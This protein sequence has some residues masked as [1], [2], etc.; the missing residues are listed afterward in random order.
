MSRISIAILQAENSI[1]VLDFSCLKALRSGDTLVVWKLDRLG[2][3]LKH[4]IEIVYD[5][6]NRNISFKV[7]TGDGSNIDKTT[8][9][10]R[11]IFSILHLLL[12]MREN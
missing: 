6:Q 7:I 2:R 8:A 11:L 4:L 5:L 12:R 10:G 9:N 1:V 3:D